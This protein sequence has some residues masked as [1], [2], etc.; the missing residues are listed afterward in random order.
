ME[1]VSAALGNAT[2]VETT[3]KLFSILRSDPENKVAIAALSATTNQEAL[4]VIA[5]VLDE[6]PN[7]TKQEEIAAIYALGS[8]SSEYSVTSLQNLI[9]DSDPEISSAANEALKNLSSKYPGLVP[10]K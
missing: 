8:I 4:P 3:S 2:S 7:A 9:S 10:L 1:T 5:R 6:D